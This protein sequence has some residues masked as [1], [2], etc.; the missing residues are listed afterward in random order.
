MKNL[1][2]EIGKTLHEASE[3]EYID[4]L[5]SNDARAKRL[6]LRSARGEEDTYGGKPHGIVPGVGKMLKT[7]HQKYWPHLP[8]HA[9][10]EEARND[11]VTLSVPLFIRCLEWAKESAKD[12]VDLHKLTDNI[13][14]LFNSKGTLD[15]EDYSS[16]FDGID[17]T[18]E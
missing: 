13:I 1:I 14:K 2:S 8:Y 10:V 6:A 16:F 12:D 7:Q 9:I 17:T 15:S 5:K 3:K 11:V 18:K 4:A